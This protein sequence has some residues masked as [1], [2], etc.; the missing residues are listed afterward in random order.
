MTNL[1][2]TP[3]VKETRFGDWFLSTQIWKTHVLSRALNDLQPMIPRGIER[4]GKI[5]DV[6]CGFGHSFVALSQCFSPGII[7]G[8]DADPDLQERASGAARNTSCTVALHSD[9]AARMSLPDG[10]FDM[11]FC[12]QTF[13]HIVEQ[14][15]AMA[16]FFRVLKPGGCLLFAESTR[17]YIHS[18]PIKLLFRHPMEIQKTA[19][20]YYEIIRDAG[21][22]LPDERI[23]TPF[24]WWSRP[25]IGF[26]EL[27]GIP[28][29]KKREETLV[30]AVAVKPF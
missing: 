20:Q 7:V 10:E 18:L 3:F 19:E 4:F 25:D 12:H 13:H 5:L 14:E 24:L 26:F 16:E 1:I 23:S 22:E 30:N 28:V 15:A 21:F 17:R 6:G 11:V 9:N 27:I 8:L 2:T 29:P